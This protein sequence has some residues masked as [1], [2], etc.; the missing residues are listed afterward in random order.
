MQSVIISRLWEY[1]QDLL[2]REKLKF[3]RELKRPATDQHVQ[4]ECH[5]AGMGTQTGS[6]VAANTCNFHET[7]RKPT[8]IRPPTQFTYH[9]WMFVPQVVHLVGFQA[10]LLWT[11]HHCLCLIC[12]EAVRNIAE[13]EESWV[14]SRGYCR[15]DNEK[16]S[17]LSLLCAVVWWNK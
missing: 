6:N 12:V 10:S 7:C 2:C 11:L 15:K 9:L 5:I 3:A 1:W 16:I 17:P 13:D 14:K 8:G 4:K